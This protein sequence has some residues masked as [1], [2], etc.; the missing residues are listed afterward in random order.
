MSNVI[1]FP[2]G[3]LDS[4]TVLQNLIDRGDVEQVYVV[5]KTKEGAYI[6]YCTDDLIGMSA[7][8]LMM[9]RIATDQ[10]MEKFE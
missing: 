5:A 2:G 4:E 7:A 1:K 3:K 9:S 8:S 10:V 6:C